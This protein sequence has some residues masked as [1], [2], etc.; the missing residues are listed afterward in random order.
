MRTPDFLGPAVRRSSGRFEL[1]HVES[2]WVLGRLVLAG[3]AN[4]RR[5]KSRDQ[6]RSAEEGVLVA[7]PSRWVHTW[8][9]LRPIDAVF[10]GA[11]GTILRVYRHLKPWRVVVALTAHAVIEAAPGFLERTETRVGDRVAVREAQ[12]AR[13]ARDVS[14]A[15]GGLETVPESVRA[16]VRKLVAAMPGEPDAEA[17]PWDLGAA[18]V[19]PPSAE[20]DGDRV[21]E[22]RVPPSSPRPD[23][24]QREP[25]LVA[26]PAIRAARGAAAASGPGP[27]VRPARRRAEIRGATLAQVLA[28]E[29]PIEWFESVAIIQ[30]LCHV[31]IEE[32]SPGGRG[33]PEADDVVIA[34]EGHIELL[35]DG[36][37]DTPV[38]R[39]AR[40]LHVL[41]EGAAMPVQLR[42][43]VLQELSP[44]PGCKSILEFSTRLALFERPGGANI[45]RG[46]YERFLRLPPRPAESAAALPAAGGDSR[47]RA[48]AVVADACR[49]SG[50]RRGGARGRALRRGRL[51]VEQRVAAPA[52]NRR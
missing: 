19:P 35:A 51:A 11:D 1:V 45:I 31:L 21:Q 47:R 43:L 16:T 38:A 44:S 15:R 6:G 52:W 23:P 40:L 41:S 12:A 3:A 48:H 27:V 2:G 50:L 13:P 17:D 29:T 39:V 10:V 34:P 7:A 26:P 25:D 30:A 20:R 18:E 9:N 37:P 4:R 24:I 32:A 42:L 28:R 46:V 36:V 33:V 14:D 22:V 5:G 8:F 49:S